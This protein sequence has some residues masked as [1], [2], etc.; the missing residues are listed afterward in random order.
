MGLVFQKEAVYGH[1]GVER[2]PGPAVECL[3]ATTV[4][5]DTLILPLPQ[6]CLLAYLNQV[7]TSLIPA[8]PLS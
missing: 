7:L 5:L 6:L 2:P 1:D 8:P 3:W 4:A